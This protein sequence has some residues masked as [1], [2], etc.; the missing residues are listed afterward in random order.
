MGTFIDVV[1][2]A[3]GSA[4]ELALRTPLST[5]V[6]MSR[7]SRFPNLAV[8]PGAERQANR[9]FRQIVGAIAKALGTEPLRGVRLSCCWHIA[10]FRC[11]A[12]FGRYPGITDFGKPSARQIYSFAA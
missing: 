3:D 10:S 2:Q 7:N 8:A 12:E 5:M 9:A 11:A 6:A 1:L 4:I